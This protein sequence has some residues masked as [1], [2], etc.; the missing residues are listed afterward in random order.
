GDTL[1]E[2]AI[3][4]AT[5]KY[6]GRIVDQREV[7][8]RLS[9]TDDD[10]VVRLAFSGI[11]GYTLPD[12]VIHSTISTTNNSEEEIQGDISVELE[13]ILG[14]IN[15]LAQH[16]ELQANQTRVFPFVLKIP[17][18]AEM[19]TAYIKSDFNSDNFSS[20]TR[21]RVKIKAIEEPLFQISYSIRNEDGK[22]VPGLV[23]RM[24][25]ITIE[26][27]GKTQVGDIDDLK[28]IL[29][30][31]SLRSVVQEFEIPFPEISGEEF[32]T[33]VKWMTPPVDI[34]T[35]Y[36]LETVIEHKGRQLPGRAIEQTEKQ[37]TV[38]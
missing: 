33:V 18:G 23:P 13:T 20:S 8:I 24:S 30:I 2:K 22:E 1:P 25:S 9:E 27:I 15:L 35:G 12:S 31:M 21:A 26:I 6:Q 3:L 17:I 32:D 4:Q 29:R 28:I 16:I 36:Y 38:Y 7:T 34:V 11:P 14:T 19:S 37:F 10:E 5:L